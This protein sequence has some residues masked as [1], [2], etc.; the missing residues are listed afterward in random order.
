MDKQTKVLVVDDNIGLLSTT[1]LILRHM[2][3]SVISAK[4]GKEALECVKE[5]G[6]EIVLSDIKM[7][8]MNGVE[9]YKQ[10]KKIIPNVP[11]VMMTAYTSDDLVQEGIREGVN[12]ILYK[13]LDMDQVIELIKRICTGKTVIN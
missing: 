7:P 5:N 10:L 2:G 4:S 13:P 1:S 11:V 12:E 6:I 3:F 8:E 9:L